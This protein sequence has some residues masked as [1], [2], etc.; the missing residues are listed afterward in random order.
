MMR[1]WAAAAARMNSRDAQDIFIVEFTALLF[2]D[3]HDAQYP[4]DQPEADLTPCML[5]CV[6]LSCSVVHQLWSLRCS[7]E[8]TT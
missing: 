1:G 4:S 2:W 7:L 5:L 3:M 8:R 6:Q